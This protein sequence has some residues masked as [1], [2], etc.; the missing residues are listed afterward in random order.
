MDEKLRHWTIVTI[1]I[2]RITCDK[3]KIWIQVIFF[4]V[5]KLNNFVN[6]YIM[7]VKFRFYFK[8][9]CVFKGGF[10]SWFKQS[11]CLSL[12]GVACFSLH[13]NLMNHETVY[14][15]TVHWFLQKGEPMTS[16]TRIGNKTLS[17][18]PLLYPR[19]ITIHKWFLP[20]LKNWKLLSNLLH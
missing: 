9:S 2:V 12:S 4:R 1:L 8:V 10:Y 17:Q 20:Q 19:V 14:D 6:Y 16:A 18:K 3:A 13:W 11:L 7:P 5:F 15:H